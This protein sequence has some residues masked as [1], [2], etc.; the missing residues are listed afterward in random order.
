MAYNKG[1]WSEFYAFLNVLSFGELYGADENLERD[2]TVRYEIISAFQKD[3]EYLRNIEQNEVV[4]RFEDNDYSLS[5]DELQASSVTLFEAISTG[6]GAS[7]EI[8]SIEPLL[9]SLHITTL[10]AGSRSKGDL[11]LK[12][13]DFFTGRDEKLN[14]SVKSYIGSKPTLLN[15]SRATVISYSLDNEQLTEERI[16]EINSI[17]GSSKIKNRIQ[18]IIDENIDINYSNISSETFKTNLEMIDFR[19]PEILANLYLKSYFV[20]GKKINDVVEDYLNDNPNENRTLIV[21]KV[22]Q[23]LLASALGMVPAT[24]W[25]GID[26]AT[27]GYIIIKDNSDVLCY[28]IYNRNRLSEYIYNNT[29]FDTPSL[30]RVNGGII[31]TLDD[32]TKELRLSVQIRF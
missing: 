29:K 5:I 20:Q 4:F 1:E 32:G 12:I 14:F 6:T 28:H 26:E 31:T 22:K 15:S 30:N 21:Y 13:N 3:I 19:M 7:F 24:C 16:Q 17:T 8:D 10:K 18:E 9:N 27:G 2:D 11:T 25:T 23:L